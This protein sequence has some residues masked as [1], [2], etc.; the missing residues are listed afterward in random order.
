[1]KKYF[2]AFVMLATA[3]L[4]F[5]LT[6]NAAVYKGPSG[7]GMIKLFEKPP[8]VSNDVSFDFSVLPT[9]REMIARVATK[10]VDIAVFPVNIAAKL[11]SK[12]PGYKLGAVT[13][14]G[15]FSL[16]SR[17]SISSWS[18]L[19]GKTIYSVGKGATPEY[20]LSYLAGKNGISL[21]TETE[22]IYSV[23]SASQLAQLI[24]GGK[25]RS[26]VLPEPFVS[27]VK[28]KAPDVKAVL[29]FQD[30]WKK[31]NNSEKTFP[32]TVVVIN[33]DL[34][35]SN[36]HAVKVFLEAYRDSIDWVNKNPKEASVLIE[37]YGVLSASVAKAAI[38]NCN[39]EY[40]PAHEA[41]P[42]I[43]EFLTVMLKANPVS[44]GGVLPNESF[45]LEE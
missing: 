24:I 3:T 4:S 10:E 45:Y 27:L 8:I 28:M 9:P 7:F 40:I 41:Q 19:K 22:V 30:E 36:P 35:K 44:V 26:A 2:F 5:T 1:M 18:D 38:P 15:I 32:V 20:L 43:E 14:M 33:P 42:L 39:L 21:S 16:L 12:G 37:K 34:V 25:V 13:G 6:I 31:V 11:Y 17:D 23:T 29:D